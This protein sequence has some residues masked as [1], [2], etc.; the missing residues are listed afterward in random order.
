[1]SFERDRTATHCGLAALR[2]ALSLHGLGWYEGRELNLK[3]M[4]KLFGVSKLRVMLHGVNEHAITAAARSLGLEVMS[5]VYV[6]NNP[7]AVITDLR[8]ATA[9]KHS[10]IISWHNETS[11][12]FHWVCVAGFDDDLNVM[13]FDPARLDEDLPWRQF[14]PIDDREQYVPAMMSL[15]RF[16]EWITPDVPPKDDC[17]HFFLEF[18]PTS[19]QL[20]TGMVDVSLLK[21]MR[22]TSELVEHFDEYLD[23][24]HSIFSHDCP[25]QPAHEF[26]TQHAP[27]LWGMVQDWTLPDTCHISAIQHELDVLTALTKCYNFV[28]PF[29]TETHARAMTQLGFHLGW[30][31]CAYS[32]GVG[33]YE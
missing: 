8:T 28:V 11:C 23:D 13:L 10:C 24:L 22:K 31:A 14:S 32:Y 5:H 12:H 33:R 6:K 25:G 30:W 29:G 15:Q 27:Y 19:A 16:R 17:S 7:D 20:V 18:I 21:L 1:M 2:Y 3:T 9:Q 4:R 26:I